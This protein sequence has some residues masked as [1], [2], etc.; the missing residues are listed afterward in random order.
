MSAASRPRQPN[1]LRWLG[2][3]L[4]GLHLI[5]VVLLGASLLGAPIAGGMA[6]T[7]VLATG[8]TLFGIDL[9]NKPGYLREA[10]GV[11]L[12]VK[13]A[14]VG[15]MAFDASARPVLFWLVV[16]GS[17][18]F[19]HAPASFRHAVLFRPPKPPKD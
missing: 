7:A 3:A 4:R 15:W 18:V 5:A 1:W 17:A 13:L 2:V 12:L 16:A 10:S 8:L 6:A 11:S 14:L 19:A 9:H